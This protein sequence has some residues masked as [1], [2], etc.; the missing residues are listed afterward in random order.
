[1]HEAH[2]R[3]LHEGNGGQQYV[4]LLHVL[5]DDHCALDVSHGELRALDQ[6]R[7]DYVDS[8]PL[9]P[10]PEDRRIAWNATPRR[11]REERVTD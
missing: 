7:L 4:A 2:G 3:L 1:M 8:A 5:V 11:I 10:Q 9:P 6:G